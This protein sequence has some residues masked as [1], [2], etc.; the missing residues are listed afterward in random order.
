MAFRLVHGLLK[1]IKIPECIL[2]H[3][4]AWTIRSGQAYSILEV[5]GPSLDLD[6]SFPVIHPAHTLVSLEL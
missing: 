1:E 5:W 6:C 4:P 2:S 3:L